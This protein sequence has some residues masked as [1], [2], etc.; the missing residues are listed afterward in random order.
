MLHAV[1]RRA[2]VFSL[3]LGL[4]GLTLAQTGSAQEWLG[5]KAKA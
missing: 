1:L 5:K 3:A 2:G 4:L